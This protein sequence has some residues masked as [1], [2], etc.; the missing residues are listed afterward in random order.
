MTDGELKTM[1]TIVQSLPAFGGYDAAFLPKAAED[2]TY[3]LAQEAGSTRWS[4]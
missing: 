1:E 2:C 4:I 3:I